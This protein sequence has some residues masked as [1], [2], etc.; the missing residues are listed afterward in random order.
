MTL[1]NPQR[2]NLNKLEGEKFSHDFKEQTKKK[3]PT[4]KINK[5][6]ITQRV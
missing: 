4:F 5:R 2:S 3:K 1:T 6:E